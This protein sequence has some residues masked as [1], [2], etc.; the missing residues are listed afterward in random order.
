MAEE[1][2]FARL[3]NT[4]SPTAR[5][6]VLEAGER[7]APIQLRLIDAEPSDT[8]YQCISYDR[9][10]DFGSIDVTV[11]GQPLPVPRPLAEALRVLRKQ[12]RPRTFWADLL[13]GSTVEERSRQASSMKSAVAN[14]DSVI[15]WLGPGDAHTEAAFEIL[16]ELSN[17]WQQACLYSG[18]PPIVTRATHK[19]MVAQYE[20]LASKGL[21]DL[22]SSNKAAW[23]SVAATLSASYFSSV[24]SIP[25][26][27]L[28]R[29]VNITF[30]SN[31]LPW[32]DYVNASRV[33]PFVMSQLLDLPV[34]QAQKT[35]FEQINTLEI[36][37]RRKR[38]SETLELFPMIQQAR[39]CSTSDLRE[40]VFS[41][42][43]IITPSKRT[44]EKEPP[45]VADYT[46]SVQDVFTDAARYIVHERQDLLLWWSESPPR[47][48]QV[49]GLPSWVP[50]WS[51]GLP[52]LTVKVM[53]TDKNGMRTWWDKIS[54]APKRIRVDDAQA[55]HV[56]AHALDKIDSISELLTADNCRRTCL[57]MWQA[58]PD[59]PDETREAKMEKMW[60]A[61]VLNQSTATSGESFRNPAAPPM[62]M[63][64]SFFSVICEER[65]LELLDCTQDQLPTR[66]DLIDRAKTHPEMSSLGP[67]TGR[68]PPFEQLLHTNALGRRFFTTSNGR[69]GMTAVEAL[70]PNE[71]N[72]PASDEPASQPLPQAPDFDHMMHDPL[73]RSMLSHFQQYVQA[74][75]PA[76]AR[77]LNKGLDGDLAGQRPPGARVGDIVVALVGGFQ[78]YILRPVREHEPSGE[79][80]Q[81]T[82]ESVS[83]YRFVGECYMHGVMDG[84]PFKG[85]NLLGWQRWKADVKLVDISIV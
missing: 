33:A 53:P 35:C 49:L 52:A 18:F 15:A 83:K 17:R 8:A 28:A 46:K 38:Q 20:H 81:R 1:N 12:D 10:Q 63:W 72:E 50:D 48:R 61:L 76:A 66:P 51:N 79:S 75:D 2:P 55:L 25:D 34:P 54:P 60:R 67:Y 74:R 68:S 45:P 44:E 30:G 11:D 41:M 26:I 62:E 85:A 59:V 36:A 16:Q 6:A 24:Q 5:L 40:I 80:S 22:Q 73:A 39:D 42:L 13:V 32:A 47:R 31:S 27:V 7:E 43:P 77:A 58:L 23:E 4:P 71:P 37:E 57:K 9:S 56:Q 14:A 64:Q 69:V 3:F 82:L 19:Q 78:P 65:I 84:E 21:D 70:A 29:S